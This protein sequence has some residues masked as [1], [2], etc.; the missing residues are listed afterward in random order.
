MSY[1]IPQFIPVA[2]PMMAILQNHQLAVEFRQEVAHREAFD[3]YVNWYREMATQHQAEVKRMEKDIN[4]FRFF[5][6]Q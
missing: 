5:L 6:R 4:F 2:P 3:Q 1:E